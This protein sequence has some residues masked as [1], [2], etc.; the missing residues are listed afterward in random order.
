MATFV[1][2]EVPDYKFAMSIYICIRTHDSDRSFEPIFMKFTR[3]VRLPPWV[4]PIVFGNKRLNG[5][6]PKTGFLAFIP[7]VWAFLRK[8]LKHSIRYFI[9]HRKSYIHFCPPKM[10]LPPPPKKNKYIWLLLWKILFCF[11]FF[12]KLLNEK[13]S[14]PLFLFKKRLY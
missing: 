3:L 8:K 2:L 6:A 5:I 1:V 14:K 12:E 10:I 11:F 13:Y 4:T 9:F 7:P